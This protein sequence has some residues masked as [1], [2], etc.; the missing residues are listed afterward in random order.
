MNTID[1]KLDELWFMQDLMPNIEALKDYDGEDG[2]VYLFEWVIHSTLFDDY[3][4]LISP[5]TRWSGSR[6]G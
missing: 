5:D 6:G 2:E 3:S 1:T 4:H